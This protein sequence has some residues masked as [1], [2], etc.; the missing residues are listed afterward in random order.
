MIMIRVNLHEAKANLSH[1][2]R[3]VEQGET[4]VVCRRNVAIAELRAVP[5]RRLEPRP[6]GLE[7]GR[8][9]VT[10]AFFEPLPEELIEA[11][12]GK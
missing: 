12:E 5:V 11:F 1:Y 7:K 6:I 9:E 2:L 3:L 10:D 4:V 8:F